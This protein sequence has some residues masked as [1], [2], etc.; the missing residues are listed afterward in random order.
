MLR[1]VNYLPNCREGRGGPLILWPVIESTTK[2][3]QK[4]GRKKKHMMLPH[5]QSRVSDTKIS[6]FFFSSPANKSH[7]LLD[8]NQVLPQQKH[9]KSLSHFPITAAQTM[10]HC[11]GHIR[12]GVAIGGFSGISLSLVPL[13]GSKRC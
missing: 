2:E 8:L 6:I 5:Q 12:G 3:G 9:R 13:Q 4:D 1:Q 11:C 10:E 7:P